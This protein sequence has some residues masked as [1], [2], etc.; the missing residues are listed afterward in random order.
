MV[1]KKAKKGG[2][3]QVDTPTPVEILPLFKNL[4]LSIAAGKLTAI[5]GTVDLAH[6]MDVRSN[7]L[8]GRELNQSRLDDVI[9]SCGWLLTSSSSNMDWIPRSVRKVSHSRVVRKLVFHLG[10]CLPFNLTFLL[11]INLAIARAVYSDADIYLL[12]DPLAALD[13]HVGKHVFDELIKKSLDGK[14]RVLVT[15]QLHVL[16]HVDHIIVLDKGVIV[17]QGSFEQLAINGPETGLLKEMLKNHALEDESTKVKKTKTVIRLKRKLMGL[18]KE[19]DRQTG[20]VGKKYV[21]NYFK[22]SGGF[23]MLY[24]IILASLL[25]GA[26]SFMQNLWLTFWSDDSYGQTTRWGLHPSDYITV[27]TI[28][29]AATFVFGA[30]MVGIIEFT[31]YRTS[32]A[33]HAKAVAGL[34][35]APMSFFD[36]QPLGRIINRLTNLEQYG[37][38]LRTFGTWIFKTLQQSYTRRFTLLSFVFFLSFLYYYLLEMYRSNQREIRRLAALQ[39]SPLNAYISECIGGSS[40]IRAFQVSARTIHHQPW[41]ICFFNSIT[42]FSR[43]ESDFVAA[44]RL[45]LYCNDL[46]REAPDH[47]DSDPVEGTWPT[48]GRIS[49]K[50][51]EVKYSS[52]FDPVIKNLSVEIKGSEKIGVVGRTGS[53]KST[54]M[55]ALFRIVEPTKGT[56][57]IDGVDVS[58][59]GLNALRSR[60]QI[61]PQDPVLFTGTI[62]SNID[63][64]GLKDYVSELTEKLDAPVAERGENLSVGQRQLMMLASAIC[65]RPK[66]LI[67]D[68]A[69]S[70]VDQAADL[71]I[72]SSIHTHFKE[73]TV[74]SIAH[75]IN[76]IASFDR[77]MVLDAGKLVEYDSPGN[78]LKQPE[79]IFKSLVDATGTA[80]AAVVTAIANHTL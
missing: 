54:L 75:R 13:A 43:L 27:Y 25:Y 65:H 20:A 16:P 41:E 52:K 53:G 76:T 51:L 37:Q 34:F 67:M 50:D 8:F 29:V 6:V 1:D 68:E 15:H 38:L 47:L 26:L 18:L 19:E 49:I 48:E 69:S 58:R 14:T 42:A 24:I 2:K 72:Q 35:R 59:V 77:I 9:H 10:N 73:T 56:V 70:A 60:L 62:R 17:E 80:N 33:Y 12:D 7:I 79:S 64:E 32:K 57:L 23:Y 55:T 39:R 61:I 31:A 36:S 21:A 22:E 74:I 71:L 40:T 11:I 44:E 28:V 78:L 5:V 3:K 46:E 66:I 45:D 30:F 63:V 4:D